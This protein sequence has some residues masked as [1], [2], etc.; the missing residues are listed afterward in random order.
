MRVFATGFFHKSSSPRPLKITLGSF[1]FCSK[2]GRDIC[3][4]RCTT[5]P[6]STTPVANFCRQCQ[7][8]IVRQI[9]KISWH[10]AFTPY[11]E[12]YSDQKAA[13]LLTHFSAAKKMFGPVVTMLFL[14]HFITK[15]D[16]FYI[17]IGDGKCY[18]LSDKTAFKW[19]LSEKKI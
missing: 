1:K 5:T 19:E 13:I 17:T 9:S 8:H 10:S 7:P 15:C 3:K 18:N 4:P 14:Q 16:T 2:I 6:V 12:K 11:S